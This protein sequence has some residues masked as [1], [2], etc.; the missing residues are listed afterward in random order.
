LVAEDKKVGSHFLTAA[1]HAG[2]RRHAVGLGLAAGD[3][4][5]RRG[6]RLSLFDKP[7][8]YAAFEKILG[9]AYERTGLRITAYCLKSDHWHL[10]LWPRRERALCDVLRWITVT[11]LACPSQTSRTGAV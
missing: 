3:L 2:S 1:G 4:A 10:L 6:G 7:A 5:Y 9:K 11:Q 8:D